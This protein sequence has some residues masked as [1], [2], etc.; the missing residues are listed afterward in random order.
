MRH[1]EESPGD[2]ISHQIGKSIPGGA[3]VKVKGW[4]NS[5]STRNPALYSNLESDF[6]IN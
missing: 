5:W 1:I 4:L 3:E 2:A 6:A